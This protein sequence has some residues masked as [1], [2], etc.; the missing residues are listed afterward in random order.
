MPLT[1]IG[2]YES[3][4]L[5]TGASLAQ[6][7]FPGELAAIGEV[8]AECL[9]AARELGY[10]VGGEAPSRRLLAALRVLEKRRREQHLAESIARPRP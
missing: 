2:P 4:E 10:R 7:L 3:R 9:L 8:L 5:L 1:P 6:R